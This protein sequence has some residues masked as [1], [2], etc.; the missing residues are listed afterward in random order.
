[1]TLNR[2]LSDV[3][4]LSYASVQQEYHRSMFSR[5]ILSGGAHSLCP[6]TYCVHFDHF[7]KCCS[8]DFFIVRL[9]FLQYF[10]KWYFGDYVE[11]TFLN[12]LS[13][14]SFPSLTD[15]CFPSSVV[16]KLECL[17]MP[18]RAC[19]NTNCQ[20][21]SPEILQ[22]WRPKKF[23]FPRSSQCC[24]CCWPRDHTLLPFII[25]ISFDAPIIPIWP[26]AGWFL[27]P[28][29]KSLFQSLTFLLQQDVLDS[30]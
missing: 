21:P 30:S 4:L 2:G 5:H 17:R 14:Y 25:I 19:K 22:V 3:S 23:A 12:K 20:A 7:T 10:V 24:C 15:S 1:M 11:V 26:V 28:N 9:L 27:C 29:D 8:P 13:F 6:I 16:L 18:W